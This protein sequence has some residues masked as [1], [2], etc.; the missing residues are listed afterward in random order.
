MFPCLPT[1]G[2]IVAKTEFASKEAKLFP[3]KFRNSGGH[4]MKYWG[5]RVPNALSSIF[6]DGILEDSEGRIVKYVEDMIFW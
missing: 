5:G 1:S 6:G 2:N 4:F 3:N